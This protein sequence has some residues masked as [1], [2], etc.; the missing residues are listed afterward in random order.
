MGR[1]AIQFQRGLSEPEF[2]KLYGTEAQWKIPWSKCVGLMALVAHAA[3][4]LLMDS[5]TDA[6]SGGISVGNAATKPQ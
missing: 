1:N 3:R 5:Y 4:V 2:H 6:G